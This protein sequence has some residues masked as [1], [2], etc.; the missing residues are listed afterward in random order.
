MFDLRFVS[1]GREKGT[2]EVMGYQA[3]AENGGFFGPLPVPFFWK[4][5]V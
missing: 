5:G 2:R 3:Q 4:R 1:G